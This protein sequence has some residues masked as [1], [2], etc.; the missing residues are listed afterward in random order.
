MK[1]NII[2]EAKE[3]LRIE[4]EAILEL[5]KIID[6]NFEEVVEIIIKSKGKL[7][8]SG[9]GKAGLIA[10]KVAATFSSL[11]KASFF[12]HPGEAAHGDLGMIGRED[13]VIIFSKSGSSM[14]LEIIL[15][16][17]KRIG[18]KIIGIT[19]K[20]GSYLSKQSDICL[21]IGEHKE[22]CS[23]GL[24][25]T[26]STTLMLALGDALA[27]TYLNGRPD[28]DE[29]MFAF[30]H[31]GGSLG[32]QLKLSKDLMRKEKEIVIVE[33]QILIKD[34]FIKM[35]EAR[36]GCAVIVDKGKK[37]MGIF[38]DGDLR[39]HLEKDKSLLFARK[40]EDVM[41]RNPLVIKEEELVSEALKV[42]KN[43][44]IGEIPVIDKERIV[45]GV[46][47]LKDIM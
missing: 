30:Y 43:K 6:K 23:L 1:R 10:G 9:M 32:K 47:C 8:F 13:T 38:S 19:S 34:V 26:T 44:M 24:A 27:V 31:P 41:T 14:E 16:F 4:A 28:F 12:V 7:I 36:I 45:K 15:P 11:G 18:S 2:K 25:P 21:W 17:I 39:R 22:A 33:S 42:M 29:K 35:T 20:K 40:I 37:I 5:E 3:V 46:I